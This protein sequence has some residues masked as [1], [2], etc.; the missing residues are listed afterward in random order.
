MREGAAFGATSFYVMLSLN[1]LVHWLGIYA[2][3][4]ALRTLEAL[5]GV[6]LYEGMSIVA[7][8]LQHARGVCIAGWAARRWQENRSTVPTPPLQALSAA[9][10]FSK[11][12][13]GSRRPCS[14]A[15]WLACS[16]FLSA[17]SLLAGGPPAS[18]TA[19]RNAA[20]VRRASVWVVVCAQRRLLG[21]KRC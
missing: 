17:S 9:T 15:M 16:W 21:S 11:K 2:L 7:G 6:A 8:A 19:M 3:A 14:R 20:C 4:D 12:A 10:S 5:E 1:V 18:E 13:R